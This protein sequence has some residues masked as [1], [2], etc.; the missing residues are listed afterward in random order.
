MAWISEEN[1]A[2]LA[3]EGMEPGQTLT[4]DSVVQ[5]TK[6]Y[7]WLEFEDILTIVKYVDEDHSL[8]IMNMYC[9]HATKLESVQ[10]AFEFASSYRNYNLLLALLD[11]HQHDDLLTQWCQVYELVS[12]LYHPCLNYRDI[13]SGSEQLLACIK[14]K[15]LRVK[16]KILRFS[17]YYNLKQYKMAYTLAL[18]KADALKS[19]QPGYIKSSFA[20]KIASNLAIIH[21]NAESNL[22]KAEELIL[23]TIVNPASQEY[24][25]A[26]VHQILGQILIFS[27]FEK[28]K[29]HLL[30]LINLYQKLK[31]SPADVIKNNDLPFLHNVHQKYFPLDEDMDIE[32]RAH[33]YIIRKQFDK[34]LTLLDLAEQ[35]NGKNKFNLFYRAMATDNYHIYKE[36]L[37]FAMMDG[38]I[39]Y[40]KWMF[41]K[42]EKKYLIK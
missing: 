21:Y 1:K 8:D 27:N 7:P 22:E 3:K 25:L 33:Q 24:I 12:T 23:S 30:T 16:L 9:Y 4:Y 39:I 2:L 26:N 36:A 42:F 15:T 6:K 34:A 37:H 32:E 29:Q 18:E 5:L 19:L 38:E 20:A 14:S 28:S 13:L 35:Q 17:S 40:S 10:S 41:N 11:K 31:F